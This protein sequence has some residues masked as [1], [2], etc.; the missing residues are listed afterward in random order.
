MLSH[1]DRE[2]VYHGSALVWEHKEKHGH[3]D[4]ELSL[5]ISVASVKF[6]HSFIHSFVP[7]YINQWLLHTSCVSGPA[8][9]VD[10]Q[11]SNTSPA[12]MEHTV[13]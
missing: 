3:V 9:G 10:S 8:L 5:S 13:V 6:I 1:G 12:L 11:R 7:S 4:G 2:L